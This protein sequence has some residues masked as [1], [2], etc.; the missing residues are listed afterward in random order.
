MKISLCINYTNHCPSKISKELSLFP[1][2]TGHATS[3]AP[4][5]EQLRDSESKQRCCLL[6][7]MFVAQQ[8][9]PC[10]FDKFDKC[11]SCRQFFKTLLKA[12][13]CDRGQV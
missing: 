3:L 5:A 12:Y 13:G 10:Y 7:R 4:L 8:L 1:P 2:E 9:S 11:F 6:A